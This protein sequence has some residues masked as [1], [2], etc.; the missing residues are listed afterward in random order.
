MS[1]DLIGV[2]EAAYRSAPSDA[3]WL[4][5]LAAAA[6]PLLDGGFGAASATYVVDAGRLELGEVV[7]AGVSPDVYAA[8][9]EAQAA[10]D[11]VVIGRWADMPVATARMV[12]GER[13]VESGG[14]AVA[15][16][17]GIGDN[18]TVQGFDGGPQRV[19]IWAP[20]RETLAPDATFVQRWSRV[21][22]HLASGLRLRAMV[23]LGTP[24]PAAILSPNGRVEHAEDAAKE[25]AARDA[26]RGA[27]RALDRARGNLRRADPDEALAHWTALVMGR[28]SL[29]DSFDSD[30]RRFLVARENASRAAGPPG[31]TDRERQVIVLRALGRSMKL[32]AYELG[33]STATISRAQ[34][35]AMRKLGVRRI[36]ELA[37]LLAPAPPRDASSP[38]AAAAKGAPV[39]RL[40]RL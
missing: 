29:V 18:V 6:R 12:Y 19:M 26:L 11:P 16:R 38:H 32:V 7:S 5:G 30:G 35:S 28:W 34:S 3:E 40:S 31:L 15:T 10:E 27:A 22:S 17:N 36:V 8:I 39:T 13:L 2:V 9:V 1:S 25:P 24:E 4:E 23:G 14:H 20:Q 33:L 21:A 37:P